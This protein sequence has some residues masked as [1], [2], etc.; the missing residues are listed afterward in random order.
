VKLSHMTSH[1]AGKLAPLLAVPIG[2]CE[3]HGPHLPLG[4][5]TIIAS[6]LCARLAA[7][8]PDVV[9]APALT[10]T[11]SGEHADF[12]GTLSIGID[13]TAVVLVEY[14]RS[15]DW[16][17]GIILVNG[18]G[19]NRAAVSRAVQ[20]VRAE[21]RRI[22]AWWPA[23][24]LAD[25]AGDAH[26][27]RTE[28]SL[29]LAIRPDLV[30]TD[31]LAAGEPSAIADIAH[32]LR[33]AGVKAVSASGVLGDPTAATLDEGI[34]LLDLLTDDLVASV[35]DVVATTPDDYDTR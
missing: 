27:G 17:G 14:A 20:T 22:H 16:A 1:E 29:M 34:R 33:S 32:R 35:E 9:V 4:T 19:G 25:T 28:T 30:R 12:P 15:A 10:V 23:N 7:K 2:S 26:A 8:R 11:A 21:G 24:A 31:H 18:H 13:V 6:A 3:Q 5:D